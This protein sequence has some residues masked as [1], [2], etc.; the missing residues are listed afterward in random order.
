MIQ[1]RTI[2]TATAVFT[3]FLSLVSI[4][5]ASG[6]VDQE[7]R[8]RKYH[9]N[10][11]SVQLGPRPYYL[12]DD[13]A[14]SQL[15]SKLQSCAN[16]PFKK[17]EFSIG[18][19]GAALQFPE[20]TKQSYEAA[21]RMGAG[22]V[23]CDVT[24]TKDKELVCR[25]SQCDLQS[26]TNILATPLAAKCAVPFTP[27]NSA[28]GAPASATCCTT[29]ITLEEFKT[30]KGKMDAFNP[31]ATTV[32]EYMN[33]TPSFRTDLY[34]AVGT[35]MTHKE[36]IELF[37]QLGVKMTPELKAPSVT[38]PYEGTYTQ[39]DYA[40]QMINDYKNAGVK[41]ENVFTQSFNLNDVLYWIQH[42]PE[43][44]KQAVFLDERVDQAGGYATAV[45]GMPAIARQGVRI[46]APPMWALVTLDSNKKIV[47]SGYAVAAKA[48]GLDII[49]WTLERSG[50]LKDGGGYYYQSTTDVTNNDGDT[51]IMLDV[52]AKDVG[53]RGIFSDWPATVSYYANCMNKK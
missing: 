29:D 26:T 21:A 15:K 39:Q 20:H 19:R 38:M 24:F 42:E 30:L 47:P 32:A 37:K 1:H 17:T 6:D 46:I 28:T 12:V 22:I 53:V 4:A 44:G 11:L 2:F 45:A 31:R 36:S 3:T 51:M 49:T 52:L 7:N 13:M 40:Q 10:A 34:A 35:L 43:F 8:D 48:A 9:D 27:A 41:A 5:S 50:L 18:H 25:H 23:E 14:P 16:G 33:A